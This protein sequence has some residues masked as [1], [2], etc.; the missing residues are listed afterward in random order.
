MKV[1][2]NA[3]YFFDVHSVEDLKDAVRFIKDKDLPYYVLGHGSNVL[4]SDDGFDGVVIK[5]HIG[6]KEIEFKNVTKEKVLVLVGAGMDWDTFVAGTVETCLC[7]L[8]NLSHIPGTVGASPVQNIGAYGTDV[9]QTIKWVEVFDF[10]TEELV[11]LTNTE[12]EFEYRSSI[13]KKAKGKKYIVTKVAFLLS[14]TFK[15]NISYK[16]VSQFFI[17]YR[18]KNP[19]LQDVREAVIFIRTKKLPSVNTYGTAGSFFKNPIITAKKRDKLLKEYPQ[20]PSYEV[21]ERKFKIPAAWIM[22]HV[23]NLN[24]KR[25]GGVG[26]YETQPLAVVNYGGATAKDV[27]KFIEMLKKEVKDKTGIELEM[28]VC[29]LKNI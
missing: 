14:K 12:C 2:G 4:A 25:E 19:T 10:E 5:N 20:M 15:L 24:G 6:V 21:D 29:E 27:T 16:D 26:V 28:E 11:Q 22:D 7:G 23:C 3:R 8:E 13:F 18:R 17:D 9:S 1:G